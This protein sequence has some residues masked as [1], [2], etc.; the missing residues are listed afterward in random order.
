MT[1]AAVPSFLARVAHVDDHPTFRAGLARILDGIAEVV[2]SVGTTERLE[3]HLVDPA[4][5]RPHLVVLDYRLPGSLLSG[6]A[7]VERVVSHYRLPVVVFANAVTWDVDTGCRS[8]GAS[9]VLDKG[10]DEDA[11]RD[12]VLRVLAGEPVTGPAEAA[13]LAA[14]ADA[15]ELPLTH[16]QARALELT[17]QGLGHAATAQMMGVLPRTVETH[18]R[19]VYAKVTEAKILPP[20]EP[21][22]RRLDELR[23]LI[24][25]GAVRVRRQDGRT[26][27]RPKT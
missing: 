8:A 26:T 17:M 4:V 20:P 6:P 22:R 9:V 27:R 1:P 14:Q 15:H 13:L 7:A 24:R 21:G 3:E 16:A 23:R 18:M 19:A 12:T 11:V 25:A 10:R 2:I 5:P